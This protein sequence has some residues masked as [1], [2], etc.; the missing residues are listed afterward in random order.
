MPIATITEEVCGKVFGG[1]RGDAL[2]EEKLTF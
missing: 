1:T 2:P